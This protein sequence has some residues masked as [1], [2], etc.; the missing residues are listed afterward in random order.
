MFQKIIESSQIKNHFF[1]TLESGP[2]MTGVEIDIL[3]QEIIG[4][5]ACEQLTRELVR[6]MPE[7]VRLR[8]ILKSE[9]RTES[10][11]NHSRVEAIKQIGSI[12]NRVFL[13]FELSPKLEILGLSFRKDIAQKSTDLLLRC[14]SLQAFKDL[15][16]SVKSLGPSDLEG[17]LPSVPAEIFHDFQTLDFGRDVMSVLRLTKQSEFGVDP[18]TL[19]HLKDSLPL[20][21]TISVTVDPIPQAT[22]ETML[23]RRSK[24]T[25]SGEDMKEARKFSEAQSDLESIALD[26]SKLF[27]FEW[28]CLINR[29]DQEWLRSDRSEAER[30]LSALGEIY[31]ESVGALSSLQAMYP[32]ANPHH[33]LVEKDDVLSCYLPLASRGESKKTLNG[34]SR[35]LAIHRIDESLTYLDVFDPK[36]ESFSWCIFGRPGT[37]KSVMVNSLTRALNHDPEIKLIKIDVGGSHSRE[38]QMLGGL[39]KTLSLNEPTGINPFDIL[40]DMGATKEAV[41]ILASFLEVLILEEGEV[42]LSK[43]MKSDLERAIQLYAES[44]SET[45]SLEEFYNQLQDFPRKSLL[46]RWVGTGVYGNAFLRVDS[47][48]QLDQPL[49]YFNFS[50]ISQAQDPDYAQGGL[51]AVMAQFNFEMLKKSEHKK[52]IVFIADETPFF[53]QKCFNF[54]NL[55]IA[56]IRKEGHGFI[57]VAQKSSHVVVGGDS[58]ILDNS[59]NKIYFSHDGDEESFRA[60]NQ[61]SH[62]ALEKIKSLT[63]RQGEYS[64]AFLKDGKGE[65]VIKLRLSGSE[66]WSYTSKD[67]DKRKF[68]ELR[69]ACPSLS[70]EEVIRCLAN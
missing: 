30:K 1:H 29:R 18:T 53:I 14:V 62:G 19:S 59:P 63:R 58:G 3:D 41:Q 64:E 54:F 47:R 31:L 36:Y 33:T 61:L 43:T 23:R 22:A 49:T 69:A 11:P 38:T 39:E 26:G 12:S 55:S 42:K 20:P 65:R 52:R 56:N 13:I 6:S 7:K 25:S 35:S 10:D 5:E 50:K 67:E 68:Q 51:A 34:S 27:K 2:L 60:R 37:G 24:Q 21:Y 8:V 17:L 57:T 44:A 70:L 46:Q 66:Y 15:N 40:N 9:Y 32:G 16:V 45:A 28:L 48:L 4:T